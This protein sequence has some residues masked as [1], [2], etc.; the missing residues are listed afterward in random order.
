VDSDLD[1]LIDYDPVC[2]FT[3]YDLVELRRD[4]SELTGLEAHVTTCGGLAPDR[5]A[6]LRQHSI[7]V[8]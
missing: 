4:L 2:R 6:R 1:I 7:G 3:L 5:L 8:F